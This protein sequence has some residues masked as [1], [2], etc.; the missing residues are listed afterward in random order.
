M[1]LT[2]EQYELRRVP[3]EAIIRQFCK[4][5]W[6]DLANQFYRKEYSLGSLTNRVAGYFTTD[7]DEFP[8]DIRKLTE[9]IWNASTLVIVHTP[10]DTELSKILASYANLYLRLCNQRVN[11]VELMLKIFNYFSEQDCQADESTTYR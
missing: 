9:E 6:S 1:K 10:L 3:S 7:Y 11:F 8:R 5:A 2:F 4:P